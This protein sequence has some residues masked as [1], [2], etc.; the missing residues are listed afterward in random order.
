MAGLSWIFY[1]KVVTTAVLEPNIINVYVGAGSGKIVVAVYSNLNVKPRTLLCTSA[2]QL[3][4][5]GWNRV[6]ITSCD[7]LAAGTYWISVEVSGTAV[8]VYYPQGTD[9]YEY[10]RFGTFPNPS[11]SLN[12]VGDLSMYSTF[13]P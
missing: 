11:A 13:C 2:A 10:A 7:S 8:V 5:P 3:T 6:P 1:K 9:R 12:V 4:V